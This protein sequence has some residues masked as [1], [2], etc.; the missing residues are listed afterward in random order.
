MEKC[1]W[2]N[3]GSSI[4][5][6]AALWMIKDAEKKTINTWAKRYYH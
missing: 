2:E 1:E 3:P 4:K 6:R 5:D